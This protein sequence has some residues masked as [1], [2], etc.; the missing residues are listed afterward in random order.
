MIRVVL[1]GHLRTLAR[2]DGEV[3]LRVEGHATQRAR[4]IRALQSVSLGF[5]AGA[6]GVGS[7]Q[8]E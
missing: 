3:T 7:A 6:A 5:E 8:S 4:T 2:V 1:P